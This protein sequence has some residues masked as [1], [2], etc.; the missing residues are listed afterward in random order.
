[1]TYSPICVL[2]SA[3]VQCVFGFNSHPPLQD[4][5]TSSG[6]G[7][8]HLSKQQEFGGNIVETGYRIPL[9]RIATLAISLGI[10]GACLLVIFTAQSSLVLAQTGNIYYISPS[11]ND[12]QS[13]NSTADA[14]ATFARAWQTMVPGDTLI[15]MDGVYYQSIRPNIAGDPGAPI[16]VR[17]QNDGKATIDGQGATSPIALWA[18]GKALYFVIEGLVA[19]NGPVTR[20]QHVVEIRSDHNILRRV[21]AYDANVDDNNFVINITGNHNLVEDC[22]AGGTGRKML[23]IY[24]GADNTVRRCL[25][26]PERWDGRNANQSWPWIDGIEFYNASNNTVENSIVYGN[27]PTVAFSILAQGSNGAAKGNRILGSMALNAGRDHSGNIIQWANTRPQPSHMAPNHVQDFSNPYLRSGFG[28]YASGARVDDTLLQDV[29]AWG[30][31]GRGLSVFSTDGGANF[32]NNVVRRGTFVNNGLAF[33]RGGLEVGGNA[34]LTFL[35]SYIANSTTDAGPGA[36]IKYRYV[37]GQLMDGTDGNPEQILLPWPMQDRIQAEQGVSVN[38]LVASVVK[39]ISG[40]DDNRTPTPTVTLPDPTPTSTPSAV[41]PTPTPELT[42]VPTDGSQRRVNIPYLSAAPPPSAFEPAIF[43]FGEVGPADNHANVRLWYYDNY[44]KIAVHIIDRHLWYDTSPTEQELTDWDAVSLYLD[45]DGNVG[46]EIDDSSYR[47]VNQLWSGTDRQAMYQGNS[48]DWNLSAN[49]FTATDEWRGSSPN[50]TAWDAG[51]QA[52]FEIPFSSLGLSG[53]P[54][55]GNTWGISIALHDRDDANDTHIPDKVWPETMEPDRPATWGQLHFGVPTYNSPAATDGIIT[56]RQGLNGAIVKDAHVGGHGNCGGTMDAWTE[57]PLA[58]YA[59]YDQFN[60]QNQW[61]IADYMCF[62]KYYVIFPLDSLPANKSIVSAT[63]TLTLFGNAGY[64]GDQAKPSAINVL[65]IAEDW[66]EQTINWNNAPLAIENIGVT[67]VDPVDSTKR[68]PYEWDVSR[69]VA[70]A[71]ARGE[72][73]RLAFYSTDGDYHSGKYF[74][75]SDFTGGDRSRPTLTI[76]WGDQVAGVAN[77]DV[78]CD[79]TSNSVDALFVLQNDVGLRQAGTQCPPIPDALYTPGC[80]VSADGQC[81]SV[82]SMYILE[83]T[84]G[85][86]NG[87]CPNSSATYLPESSSQNQAATLAIGSTL[88]E[89]NSR[90]TI[91]VRATIP[92]IG[93]GAATFNIRYDST[94]LELLS[95]DA[96]PEGIF[97]IALCNA[98]YGLDADGTETTRIGL[99]SVSGVSGAQT[100]ARLHFRVIGQGGNK[101]KVTIEPDSWVD[102]NGVE[103]RVA[104]KEAIVSILA[105]G[106]KNGVFLPHV[107]R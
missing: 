25:M 98:E 22:V 72:P 103:L 101:T 95:C 97:D 46:N 73:L 44:M 6:N 85:A 31:A 61:D 15:V 35:D 3:T 51:W 75:S 42:S 12:S 26:L 30:N 29:I 53:P 81:N 56:I 47:F 65:S 36:Q 5:E 4:N 27:S 106:E 96:D 83:C 20:G 58:N 80:D 68:V 105:S 52:Y 2:Q 69:A 82:D 88:A 77:G 41:L 84:A 49:P 78:N 16:T 62:S 48:A 50:S 55:P 87:W 94:M 1:M 107:S 102:D 90:L 104:S 93:V 74:W 34:N 38:D 70:A 10:L 23:V 64:T 17:A 71:Y 89:P 8:L 66:D 54:T 99:T 14:W 63:V 39:S 76:A 79:N 91:P 24:G 67:W 7:R 13:G 21:S 9:R 86:S 37:D 19:R 60:I 18:E 43:W 57:W 33:D 11:G 32:S 59:G 40:V 28:F 45:L 92:E 100:V